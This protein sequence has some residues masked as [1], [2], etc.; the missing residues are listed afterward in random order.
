MI[1]IAGDDLDAEE[2][3][4]EAEHA[5]DHA[6]DREPRAQGLVVEIILLAAH[7]LGPVAELPRVQRT[8][9]VAGL[10]GAVVLELD[11]FSLE[12]R[13]DA[14]AD[15]LDELQRRVARAGHAAGGGEI[16]EVLL[17]QKAGLLV[18]QGE[19]LADQRGVVPGVL[20]ADLTEA[21]PALAAQVFVVGVLQHRKD[22][23]GL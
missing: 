23:G 22:R 2:P 15:V 1:S 6:V 7:L 9:G 20:Q 16:G 19:D 14:L 5:G 4:E 8:Q 18:A 10:G 17:A 21:F 13:A 3:T 11:A 12:L